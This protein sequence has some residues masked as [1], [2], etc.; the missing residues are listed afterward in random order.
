MSHGQLSRTGRFDTTLIQRESHGMPGRFPLPQH[1]R[2]SFRVF[3]PDDLPDLRALYGTPEA[4]RYV[5][6]DG[7]A[8]S[9]ADLLDAVVT[10]HDE[11]HRI[12]YTKW[13]VD[14]VDGR[15]IGRAGVSP[16]PSSAHEAELGYCVLQEEWG[17]GI[18][19]EL[20]TIVRDW[21]WQHTTLPY[22][23]G[24][25]HPANAASQRVLTKIGMAGTGRRELWGRAY[26]CFRI[27]RP[28]AN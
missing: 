19:T 16:M 3:T 1:P 7:H 21:A 14:T 28:I 27:D 8:W 2:Y 26:E 6:A 24:F 9:D 23:I 5:S 13:R 20:A 11:F 10:W 22:L 12:G 18:A 25:T 15:F 4:V 17:K